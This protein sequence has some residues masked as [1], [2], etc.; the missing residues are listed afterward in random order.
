VAVLWV[1]LWLLLVQLIRTSRPLYGLLASKHGTQK[2]L[3]VRA[4]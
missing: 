1:L 2:N 4:L 3:R